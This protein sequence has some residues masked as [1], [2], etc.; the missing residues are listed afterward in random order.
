MALSVIYPE[1]ALLGLAVVLL[2]LD[3]AWPRLRAGL[4]YLAALG[5]FLEEVRRGCVGNKI[6]YALLRTSQPLDAALAAYLSNRMG[7]NRRS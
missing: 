5:T 7:T 2:L 1:L 3:L 6:D 4:G